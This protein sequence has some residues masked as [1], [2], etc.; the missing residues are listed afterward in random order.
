MPPVRV[1]LVDDNSEFLQAEAEMM[2]EVFSVVG[3]L[4]NGKSV[5]P[6]VAELKPDVVVLDLSLGDMTGFEVVRRLKAA[7][8]KTRVVFL[9]IHEGEEFVEAAMKLGV[10]G[11]VFKS[12]AV[13]D[14]APAIQAASRGETYLSR[15]IV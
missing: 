13:Q 1:L 15:G 2:R 11:Y 8:A 9:T 3:T 12:Q 5:L 4:S 7:G 14:L 10:A 6:A